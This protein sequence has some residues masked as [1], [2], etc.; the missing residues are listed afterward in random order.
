M[1]GLLIHMAPW[2][3]LQKDT[4]SRMTYEKKTLPLG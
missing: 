4:V 1:P 2:C 3:R